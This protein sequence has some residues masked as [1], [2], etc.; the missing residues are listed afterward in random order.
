M[1]GMSRPEEAR[2]RWARIISEQRESGETVAGFCAV[3]GISVS[4]FYPWKRRLGGTAG[5]ADRSA[6]V[7][8][9]VSGVD[10]GSGYSEAAFGGADNERDGGVVIELG[11]GRRVSVTRGFDRLLL[12][13]VIEA[14]ESDAGRGS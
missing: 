3:R 10:A 7:E 2:Q 8:A 13:D 4:S 6:F 1:S 11:R 9:K 12:L 14:L 5:C